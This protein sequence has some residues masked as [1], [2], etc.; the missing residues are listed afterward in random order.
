MDNE[1]ASPNDAQRNDDLAYTDLDSARYHEADALLD[2]ALDL[3]IEKRE[4]YIEAACGGDKALQRKVEVLLAFGEEDGDGGQRGETRKDWR[5]LLQQV[6]EDEQARYEGALAGRRFGPWLLKRELGRG[7]MGLVYL[8]RHAETG[9]AAAVKLVPPALA[10]PQLLKRF[11][12]ERRALAKLPHTGI[13]GLLDGGVAEDGT[14]FFAMEYADGEPITSYCARHRL[15]LRERVRLFL[16]VCEA[17]QAAHQRLV[18]HRD[19]KPSNVFAVEE[20]GRPLV[21]LLDFGIAKVLAED[22]EA[23]EAD[24][25]VTATGERLMT[26]AYAAP[27][28]V[29]GGAVTTATDVYALGVLFY[30]LVTG[31]RPYRVKV[32]GAGA[33]I[34]VAEA[35][36]VRP[37]TAVARTNGGGVGAAEMRAGLPVPSKLAQRLRGDLDAICM[38]ALRRGAESRYP[39]AQSMAD[40]LDRYLSA[41]PVAARR[42]SG[43]YRAAKYVRRHRVAF[44]VAT[45]FALLVSGLV[46]FYTERLTEERDRARAEAEEAEHVAAFLSD[47][48]DPMADPMAS[49]IDLPTDTIYQFIRLHERKIYARPDTLRARTLLDR[50]RF[51][52]EAAPPEDP[53]VRATLLYLIG[54]L[55]LH[56]ALFDEALPPLE[57][58]FM[59]RRTELGW[60]HTE[61]AETALELSGVYR[62]IGQFEESVALLEETTDALRRERP[63]AVS[64]LRSALYALEWVHRERGAALEAAEAVTR[65]GIALDRTALAETRPGSEAFTDASEALASSLSSLGDVRRDL[66]R[67]AVAVAPYREALALYRQLLD[68]GR[69]F[70]MRGRRLSSSTHKELLLGHDRLA[71]ALIASGRPEEAVALYRGT[72]RRGRFGPSDESGGLV[73]QSAYRYGLAHALAAQG[74]AGEAERVR[75]NALT[76]TKHLPSE[77][78]F[79]YADFLTDLGQILVDLERYEDAAGLLR[80]ALRFQRAL[81]G[82][83]PN[84]AVYGVSY[85]EILYSLGDALAGAGRCS[86]AVRRYEEASLLEPKVEGGVPWL[87]SN[88]GMYMDLNGSLSYLVDCLVQLGE[89]DQVAKVLQTCYAWQAKVYGPSWWS[90]RRVA[91]RLAAFHE[92]QGRA[93]EA[94]RWYQLSGGVR[95]IR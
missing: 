69:D 51:Q 55:Y 30:E 60:E 86:A 48:F 6:V 22:D 24:L 4:A 62:S 61:T 3:P 57:K 45:S 36:V 1:K 2:A 18:V 70:L 87:F 91:G 50:A 89:H 35:D 94:A 85:T 59:L 75:R 9:K 14:P 54:S 27:E 20:G 13:A 39:T 44:I 71:K 23:G 29:T 90:T 80:E 41:R 37:S 40:D 53:V 74:S 26:P 32:E 38:K 65:E 46:A 16:Q 21:K 76:V 12:A 31:Q 83:R 8:A 68:G 52:F 78:D 72:L 5:G 84:D 15:G 17:V 66:G 42:G 47:L 79:G 58:A 43:L 25:P 28:Q 33:V 92:A 73:Y 10:S 56:F 88:T 11:E 95:P 82:P 77:G 19:L 93:A 34:A 7:G 63:D 49:I 81:S 67:P 64:Q